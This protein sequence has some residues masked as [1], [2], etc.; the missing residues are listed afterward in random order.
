M[1]RYICIWVE[2]NDG[3]LYWH[4]NRFLYRMILLPSPMTFDCCADKLCVCWSLWTCC[5]NSF[6]S[7][8]CCFV[9]VVIRPSQL[10]SPVFSSYIYSLLYSIIRL[11]SS[12]RLF[13]SF[14][15]K[16]TLWKFAIIVSLLKYLVLHIY[17]NTREI[18][19]VKVSSNELFLTSA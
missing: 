2:D 7:L 17:A 4:R 5:D 15:D 9:T 8:P 16:R 1:I 13:E 10:F 19:I 18:F 3:S 6:I 11:V 12:Y 14:L